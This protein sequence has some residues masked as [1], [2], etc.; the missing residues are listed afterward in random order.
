MSQPPGP[1][2]PYGQ[3]S[4]PNR[5][6]QP[7][8]PGPY[9]PQ[10]QP[11]P[12]YGLPAPPPQP[13]GSPSQPPG[14]FPPG[15]YGPP[16]QPPQKKN[17]LLPWLIVGAAVLVSG[18]GILLVVLL[19]GDDDT[20]TANQ[21]TAA[22][23]SSSA[24]ATSSS[25]EPSQE[26][27]TGDLPGGAQVAEPTADSGGQFEGSGEVALTWVQALADGEFQTAYDLSCAEVRDAAAAAAI[28]G[29]EDPAWELATYFYE[30]TLGG[31]GFTE[32]SFD[33][34]T[35]QAAS[36][37]DM[38]AFTLQLDNGETFTLLVYVGPDLTV[39]DFF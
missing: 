23:S 31:V 36:N 8:Q 20:P 28:G 6:G 9:Q 19:T 12:S 16:P 10:G 17:G 18:L 14:G 38:A 25:A 37:Q 33:S 3:P 1:Y 4:D 27:A 32:G 35:Y 30:Q 15:G 34:V 21:A 39:C 7:Y 13:Y 22:S 5:P 29:T 26:S 24:P 11:T 2:G